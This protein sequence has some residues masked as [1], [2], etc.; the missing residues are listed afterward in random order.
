MSVQLK[1]IRIEKGLSQVKLARISGVAQ[2]SISEIES[3]KTKPIITTLEKLAA[4]LDV[5]VAALLGDGEGQGKNVQ[6]DC[7]TA[8]G[9]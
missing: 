5:P 1:K 7:T 6:D 9:A 4:A 3:G 8:T 2:S